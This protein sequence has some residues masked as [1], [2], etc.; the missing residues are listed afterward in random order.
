MRRVVVTGLGA[1]SP[2]GNGKDEFWSAVKAGKSGIG[3]VERFDASEYTCQVAAEVKD[4]D[5]AQYIDKRE[6][7]RMDRYCQFA[8]AAAKMALE[9]SGLA[10]ENEDLNRIGVITGSG[11]G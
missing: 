11:I 4:F 8:V 7:R 1:I 9:D 6:A 10:L 5:P 3:K 2:N